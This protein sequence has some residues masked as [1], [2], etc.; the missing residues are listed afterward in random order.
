MAMLP[1]PVLF[2]SELGTKGSVLVPAYQAPDFATDRGV[3]AGSRAI[4]KELHPRHIAS[5]CVFH[6]ANAPLA[7]LSSLVVLFESTSRPVAVLFSP[8]CCYKAPIAMRGIAIAGTVVE[9][10]KCSTRRVIM[11]PNY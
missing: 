9:E 11:S 1:P 5:A 4:E 6:D 3:A 10:C 7:V 2:Q 8:W